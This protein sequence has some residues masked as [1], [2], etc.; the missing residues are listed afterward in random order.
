M[1]EERAQRRELS[2]ASSAEAMIDSL[3]VCVG[4]KVLVE[5]NQDA[6]FL[7]AKVTFVGSS[8]PGCRACDVVR[9]LIA[10]PG[11]LLVGDLSGR[12]Q[13]GDQ[14]VNGFSVEISGSG[15]CSRFQMVDHSAGSGERSFAEGTA[16]AATVSVTAQMLQK[17]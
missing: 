7:V 12:V 1:A 13:L 6:I 17:R 2:R 8:V 11:Q 5:S 16:D 14:T 4:T 10:V 9:V 3:P 15:T